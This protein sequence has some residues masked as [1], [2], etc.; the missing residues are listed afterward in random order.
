M[1]GRRAIYRT[2]AFAIGVSLP[3]LAV[4]ATLA[5][6]GFL[7]V[8]PALVGGAATL[9]GTGLVVG[10]SLAALRRVQD[11]VATLAVDH[12]AVDAVSR[13][14]PRRLAPIAAELWLAVVRLTR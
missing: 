2:A 8:R 10:R 12:A 9:V 13:N 11:A 3:G 6:G 1:I 14:I 4:L 7:A 5:G